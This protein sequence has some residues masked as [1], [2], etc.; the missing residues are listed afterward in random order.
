[1]GF[2]NNIICL[3]G[4]SR[5]GKTSLAKYIVKKY[6]YIPLAIGDNMKSAL[7]GCFSLFYNINVNKS[8]L[9]DKSKDHNGFNIESKGVSRKIGFMYKKP[10]KLIDMTSKVKEITYREYMQL[11]SNDI[12]KKRLGDDIWVRSVTDK[13]KSMCLNT[14]DDINIII[15]DVRYENEILYLK[16][17]F[18]NVTTIKLERQT[19]IEYTHTSD[20]IDFDT[21]HI[22]TN[23]GTIEELYETY[24]HIREKNN[25]DDANNTG[26]VLML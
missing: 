24:D 16:G 4:K 18:K 22:I 26:M 10:I 6:G 8:Y 23:N 11:F 14:N 21:D 13:I 15:S 12:I 7:L 9:Y 20:L 1:M 19:E 25:G 2:V 3:C 17:E 5:S